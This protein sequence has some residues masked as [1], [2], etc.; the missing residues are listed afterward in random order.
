MQPQLLSK[1]IR[2]ITSGLQQ[3]IDVPTASFITCEKRKNYSSVS[4]VKSMSKYGQIDFPC[5][6]R[7]V[8][9]A[10]LPQF[11]FILC[12]MY[13]KQKTI[14][15]TCHYSNVTMS[16]KASQITGVSMVC[17]TVCFGADQRKHQSSASL[18]FA[19][20]IHRWPVNS[21]HKGE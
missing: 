10:L 8:H 6:S 7:I 4:V 2:H 19:R 11:C 16:L 5:V 14:W 18:A 15:K 21:P 9:A 12:F 13:T 20:G 17:S 1:H 3:K